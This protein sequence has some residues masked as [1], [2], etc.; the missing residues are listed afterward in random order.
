MNHV[1]AVLIVLFLVLSMY[2]IYYRQEDLITEPEYSLTSN[3]LNLPS[4]DGFYLGGLSVLDA[5]ENARRTDQ[6]ALA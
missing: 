3:G 2:F 4:R 5:A 1:G 6:V